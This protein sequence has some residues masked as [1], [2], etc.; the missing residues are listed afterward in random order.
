VFLADDSVSE[1]HTTV[2]I[3]PMKMEELQLFAGDTVL[4]KG[5]KR[6]DT[7]AVI[8]SDENIN[9]NKIKMTKVI[10]SNLRYR[11]QYYVYSVL[12]IYYY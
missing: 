1:D 10:R 9:E 4:L 2:S 8:N 11:Y 6:K 5:K 3:S 7:I 12:I